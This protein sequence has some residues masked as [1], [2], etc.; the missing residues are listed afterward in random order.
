M[1]QQRSD[2]TSVRDGAAE[3]AADERCEVPGADPERV[4]RGRAA[5]LDESTYAR[6]AE[7]FR[8]LADASRARI[9]HSLLRQELCTCDLAAITGQSEP[10]VSQHLR[11]LRALHLVKTHRAGKKVFY[12]LDDAH[13][14]FLLEISL[15]HLAHGPGEVA[16]R[17][18]AAL[19]H[20]HT[21][22][23]PH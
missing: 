11:L 5:L 13:V 18:P 16:A 21:D 8:A 23:S 7:I 2:Q 10:A 3:R 12:S 14:R 22:R 6:L 19:V 20:S 4:R 15:R 9:V 1:D 17:E